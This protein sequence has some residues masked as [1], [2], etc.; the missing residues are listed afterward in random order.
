MMRSQRLAM[1]DEKSDLLCVM[2]S[3]RLAMCDEKSEAC[4]V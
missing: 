4:F 2:L 3:Q 1:C